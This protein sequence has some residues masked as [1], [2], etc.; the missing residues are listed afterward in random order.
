LLGVQAVIAESYERIHRANLIGMGILPL[1]FKT[2]D[3]A[4]A[5]GLTGREIYD[6]TGIGDGSATKLSV[7]ATAP[8]DSVQ[9]FLVDVRID[10]PKEIEY[11]RHGGILHYVLRRLASD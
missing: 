1:Q 3:S 4:E 8:D 5:L 9:S 11:Y 6:F 7:T 2:G 10:T